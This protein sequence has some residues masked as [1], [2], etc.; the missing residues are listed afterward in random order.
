MREQVD[1]TSANTLGLTAKARFYTELTSRNALPDLLKWADERQL[2]VLILGEGSNV[3]LPPVFPGLVIRNAM[4]GRRIDGNRVY[5][6]AGENWHAFVDWCCAHD[7]NGLEPLA[8]IPGTVGASPV[9]NIGA[10]GAQLADFDPIVTAYDRATSQWVELDAAQAAYR[11]RDSV[12]KANLERYVIVE[13]SFA[14]TPNGLLK[15]RYPDLQTR[16]GGEGP[17]APREL[18]DAVVAVRTEKLHDPRELGNAGSFFKN[19]EISSE[20]AESIRQRFPDMPVFPVEGGSKLSAGWLIDRAGWK[21]FNE[22]AAGVSPKHALVLVN[23]GGANAG[24]IKTLADKI[25][26]SVSETFGVQL[27]PEP[28]FV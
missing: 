4:S 15:A 16:L 3:V 7:L 18:F 20:L 28:R 8:L 6:G 5:A 12:F 26:A 21:G 2:P 13:V 17:F 11:Y 10:Y 27:E 19:P 25:A 23:N 9:Q 1:L 14:L 24:D 22:S